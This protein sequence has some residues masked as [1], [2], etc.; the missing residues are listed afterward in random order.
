MLTRESI[1]ISQYN[2]IIVEIVAV[3]SLMSNESVVNASH[4]C[5]TLENRTTQTR[6]SV[7]I[8]SAKA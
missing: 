2:F 6:L 8:A 4:N 1:E 7:R 3:I 5:T